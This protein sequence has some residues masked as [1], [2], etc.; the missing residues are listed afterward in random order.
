M[1]SRLPALRKHRTDVLQ[2]ADHFIEKFS[3]AN[4]K[5]VLRISTA[6]IDMQM[7]KPTQRGSVSERNADVN[8]IKERPFRLSLFAQRGQFSFDGCELGGV[9]WINF[10]LSGGESGVGRR[11]PRQGGKHRGIRARRAR[12]RSRRAVVLPESGISRHLASPP[13]G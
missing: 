13:A 5:P 1:D 12:P 8:V 4:G 11:V 10:N 3:K 2:P 6:A 9:A 7:A